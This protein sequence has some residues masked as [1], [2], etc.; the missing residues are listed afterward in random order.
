M[1]VGSHVCMGFM[2]H[3][4]SCFQVERSA[5]TTVACQSECAHGPCGYGER[6]W[7]KGCHLIVTIRI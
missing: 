7:C 4:Q 2:S 5:V 3:G 1:K 6:V